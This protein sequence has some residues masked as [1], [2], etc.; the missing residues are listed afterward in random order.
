MAT[1]VRDIANQLSAGAAAGASGGQCT[2]T[3]EQSF[4]RVVELRNDEAGLVAFV[5]IHSLALGPALGG[6]RMFDYSSRSAAIADAC[7]LARGMSYKNA[8]AGI[9]FGGGKSVIVGDPAAKTPALLEAYAD[10]LNQLAGDYLS[11]EDS[12]ISPADIRVMRETTEFAAGGG[13]PKAIGGQA[14]TGG[15][16]PAPFTAKG[17]YLG[18]QTAVAQRLGTDSLT[19]LKVG[20]EGLGQVGFLLA[21]MLREAGATVYAS[22]LNSDRLAQAVSELGVVPVAGDALL[23]QPLDVF[24]PC[25]MGH[26]ISVARIGDLQA[27]VIAGAANNQLE[28]PALGDLLARRGQLYAPDYV[29]NAAGVVSIAGEYLGC[30]SDQWMVDQV[31]RIPRRLAVIFERAQ[32]RG[33]ATALVADRMARQV[34]RCAGQNNQ[35]KSA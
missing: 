27:P 14:S 34:L 8:L 6:V 25:A 19:D 10:G 3:A 16:N 23:Q 28:N 18:L 21:R 12:G 4:E 11:A 33:L 5:A 29:I 13:A 15:G 24:A 9:P 2:S 1:Q 32:G 26:A 17:V 30:W 22:E 31:A 20:I 35:A 7:Q